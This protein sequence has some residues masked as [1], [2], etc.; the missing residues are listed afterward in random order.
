MELEI[1]RNWWAWALRGVLAIAFG[2]AAFFWP[3]LLWLAVVYVFAAYSLVGGLLAIAAAVAGQRQYGPW[4]ALLLEGIV[5]VAFGILAFAWPL[6]TVITELMLI[7][8]I[9]FQYIFTGVLQVA[10][11]IRMRRYIR[12]EWALAVSGILSV[13]LGALFVI[14]PAVGAIV[15]AWWIAAFAIVFGVLLLVLAFRLRSVAR[16]A[17]GLAAV[18]AT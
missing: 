5:G 8:L 2:I 6:V 3:W 12:D 16:H 15:L 7:Y 10:A 1:A 13:I 14:L 11:A 4:W 17:S 18:G 9:A